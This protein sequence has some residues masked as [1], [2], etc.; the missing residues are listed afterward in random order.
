MLNCRSLKLQILHSR[1]CS[2]KYLCR[3]FQPLLPSNTY[4]SRAIAAS[5][6]LVHLLP[7][8]RLPEQTDKQKLERGTYVYKM[9]TLVNPG[10]VLGSAVS[11]F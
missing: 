3:F 1:L 4:I 6:N 7:L 11:I 8:R 5:G 10:V 9:R 2:T